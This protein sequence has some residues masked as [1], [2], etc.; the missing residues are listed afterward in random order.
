VLWDTRICSVI[1]QF[2]RC[3]PGISN[4][5]LHD[6]QLFGNREH[7][8]LILKI[9]NLYYGINTEIIESKFLNDSRFRNLSIC[10]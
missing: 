4:P 7:F 10:Q 2:E 3:E 8:Q 1:R 5:V 6:K 9:L